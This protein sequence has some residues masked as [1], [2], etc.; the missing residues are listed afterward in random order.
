MVV[1]RINL[2]ASLGNSAD[3]SLPTGHYAGIPPLP[4]GEV[5]TLTSVEG[6]REKLDEES[7]WKKCFA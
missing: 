4:T 2:S 6:G 7:I 3:P 5:F 1:E